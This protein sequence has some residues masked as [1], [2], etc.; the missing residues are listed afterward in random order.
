MKQISTLLLII[1][2]FINNFTFGISGSPQVVFEVNLLNYQDDIFHVTVYTEGLTE[3]NN[4]YNLP[5]TV[6]GTYSLLDFGRFVTSFTAFDSDGNELEVER[7]STNRWKISDIDELSII[8]Y[9]VEDT[10]DADVTEDHVIPMAGTG[11]NNDYI[12]LN[13][14]AVIG[15]FEGLQTYP[16]KMKLDYNPDWTIGTS[17]KLDEDGYYFAESYD[18]FADS[19]MLMGK[20]STATTTVNDIEVGI[21]VYSP[22][23][24]KNAQE[25][26]Q[27]ADSLL[28]ALGE[29]IGYS[30]VKNYNYLICLLDEETFREIGFMGAGALEHSYSSLFVY[31]GFGRFG[32]GL[33]DDMAHEFLHILTPLNLHSNIIQP[34]NFV[35]PTASKHLWLYEGVTEWGSDISQ[36]RGGLITTD[37]YLKKLSNKITHSDQFRQDISLTEMSLNVYSD[38]ITME[39]LNFYEKGAVTAA[40]LDIRLLELSNGTR[41]LREVFLDLLE[42]YGK[43][44]PFPEDEFFE[45]FV[46]NSYPEIED[47]INDY[48]KGTKPLPY[49]EYMTKL[50]Y[51]YIAERPSEDSRPAMGV[52]LGMND[53]QQLTIVGVEETDEDYGLQAGDVLLKVMD[54]E[55]KMENIREIF[56]N[57][58]KMKVGD[59]VNII[60]ERGNEEVTLDVTLRQ[61]MDKHIFEEMENPTSN[62]LKLRESWSKNL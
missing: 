20:L 35:T 11:I 48:I 59:T 62:Q 7:I 40:M 57:L 15:F 43:N 52:Q 16:V 23:S 55:V 10:F 22:D 54:M 42:Q 6:P 9:D 5:S 46:E 61:R 37:Q 13:T 26:V 14:F 12:V 53:K 1:Y 38:V 29:Y 58:Q 18:Y 56:G 51:K 27:V 31:P 25:V 8:T 21:Y 41:G 17:L 45:I 34:F 49:E 4:I 30:P 47:F 24:T 19:P 2:L 36:M 3:E 50:G 60:V 28:Q 44:K 33:Q 39:F 32:M